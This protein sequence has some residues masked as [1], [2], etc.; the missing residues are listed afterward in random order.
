[1]AKATGVPLAKFA[2]RVMAG[3]TLAELREEGLLK[4]PNHNGGHVSVKAPVLPFDRFPDADTLLGPEMRSTGEVMGIDVT[5]GLAFAKSQIPAGDR[6]PD[7]GTV[8]LSLADRDKATGEAAAVLFRELGFAIAATAGTAAFLEE[9]GVKI[10]TV[11]AKLGEE[12]GHDAVDLIGSGKVDLVVNWPAR[13]G[14]AGR[15]RPHPPGH[16]VGGHPRWSRRRPPASRR[17][18]AWPTGPDTSLRVRTLQE[19]HSGSPPIGS[20]PAPVTSAESPLA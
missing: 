7:S 12:T 14:P 11:V 13:S 18:G 16:G 17:P 20:E 8:F 3:A 6:L 2:S 4:A 5:F 15:Q 10:A 19:Y 9:R 1:M